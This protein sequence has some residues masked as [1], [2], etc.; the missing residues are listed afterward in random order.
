M[1]ALATG[2]LA[3]AL[4][5]CACG[6]GGGTAASNSTSQSVPPPILTLSIT[7]SSLPPTSI[8][9]SYSAAL[10]ASGGTGTLTWTP[11]GSLPPGLSLSSTGVI[12]G[13][14]ASAGLLSLTVQVTDTS[15]PPQTASKALTLDSFGFVYQLTYQP[16]PVNSPMY[17]GNY[18]VGGGVQPINWSISSGTV[19]PGMRV[20]VYTNINP[21]DAVT[22]N[23]SIVGIPTQPGTFAFTVRAQDSGT[24]ARAA[25]QTSQIVIVPAPITITTKLLPHA[26]AGQNYTSQLQ[27]TGGQAP[28][29]WTLDWTSDKLPAGL[30]L[31]PS[32]GTIHGMPTAGGLTRLIFDVTDGTRNAQQ[33]LP[34]FTAASPLPPRNDTLTTATPLFLPPAGTTYTYNASVSPYADPAKGVGPDTDY[35]TLTAPAGSAWTITVAAKD[36][37]NHSY[38]GTIYALDAVLE[39]LDTNGYRLATCND[40]FDDNPPSGVPIGKD[41]SPNGF[42]DPCMNN[43]TTADKANVAWLDFKVPGTTGDVTFYVHVFDWRGSARPDMY[44]DL[45]IAQKP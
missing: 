4:G 44:Y 12:S 30:S 37:H 10:S 8:G 38:G 20:N 27:L 43:G 17:Q 26:T 24:P 45:S 36:A 19:P 25:E 6:G 42:D 18:V 29:T 14:P 11:V 32:T 41:A 23:M 39:I 2:T 21:P 28:Y 33:S 7:T 35:Y 9:Q 31:D 3:L 1:K 40:P 13:T 22:R 5:L 16:A 34:L 15:V